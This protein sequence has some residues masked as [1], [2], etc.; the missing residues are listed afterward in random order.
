VLLG[1]YG[2][3]DRLYGG[4]GNDTLSG[5]SGDADYC[6]GGS[7]FNSAQEDHGCEIMSAI[8]S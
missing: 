7:D 6:S 5:G 8:T 3:H 4:G 2:D 1:E